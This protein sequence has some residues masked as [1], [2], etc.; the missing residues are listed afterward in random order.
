VL[1]APRSVFEWY[2]KIAVRGMAVFRLQTPEI[3]QRI[4]DAIIDRARQYFRG[5][6]LSI[7]CP[8]V[9]FT[10]RKSA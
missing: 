6:S 7:P 8:A 9:I 10:A 3:Q 4:R 1:Q 5:N 2:E